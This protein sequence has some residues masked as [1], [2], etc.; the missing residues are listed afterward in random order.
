MVAKPQAARRSSPCSGV[1]SLWPRN[2][3]FPAITTSLDGASMVGHSRRSA[4]PT[5]IFADRWSGNR[6]GAMPNRSRILR[7]HCL[8]IRNIAVSAM[9]AGHSSISMP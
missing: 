4:F 2:G 7:S 1:R 3:G 8:S 5:T 6:S 9:R